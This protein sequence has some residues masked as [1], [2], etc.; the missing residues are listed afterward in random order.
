MSSS[1]WLK[2]EDGVYRGS[3]LIATLTADGVPVL[4]K[5]KENQKSMLTR[6]LNGFKTEEPEEEELNDAPVAAAADI[7]DR[8]IELPP[9]M[10]PLLGSKT[11]EFRAWL[12]KYKPSYAELC[13]L[14]PSVKIT[15]RKE[16]QK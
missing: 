7:P 5:G 8:A 10:D 3:E 15:E 2:K 11:P 1:K 16:L 6:F 9:E 4:V 13:R 14:V 12:D